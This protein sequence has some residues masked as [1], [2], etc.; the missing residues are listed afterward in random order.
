M[1]KS[2]PE[3]QSSTPREIQIYWVGYLGCAWPH[4]QMAGKFYA[5]DRGRAGRGGYSY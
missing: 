1:D 5:I 3:Q 2:V 4:S